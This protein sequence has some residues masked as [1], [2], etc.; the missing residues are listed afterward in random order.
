MRKN[1]QEFDNKMK[2]AHDS[3]V[4]VF[5]TKCFD[6][7]TE[8]IVM[9]NLIKKNNKLNKPDYLLTSARNC[10]IPQ[11]SLICSPKNIHFLPTKYPTTPLPHETIEKY[12]IDTLFFIF[13]I[14]Q[15]IIL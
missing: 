8:E 10:I 15:V 1:F 9:I 2:A 3:T 4:Y 5:E 12:D 7:L 14:Q 6:I 11:D 13:F